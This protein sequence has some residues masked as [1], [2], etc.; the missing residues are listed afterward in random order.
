MSADERGFVRRRD[1]LA[2][3]AALG[4]MLVPA[5]GRAQ[6]PSPQVVAGTIY[7]PGGKGRRVMHDS[8][9]VPINIRGVTQ[10][11]KSIFIHFSKIFRQIHTFIAVPD[12]TIAINGLGVSM[13][14]SVN[15]A[16]AQI[17]LG[18]VFT[19]QLDPATIVEG[20]IWL[21]GLFS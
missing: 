21:C 10:D 11:D 20:N 1:L 9:H 16:M 19:R 18:R 6:E 8:V 13:G 14:A 15:T 17:Y 4:A 3:A 2:R 7:N 12:E 5:V